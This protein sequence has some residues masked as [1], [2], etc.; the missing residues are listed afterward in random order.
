MCH[1]SIGWV[2]LGPHLDWQLGAGTGA[3]FSR[4]DLCPLGVPVAQWETLGDVGW[5]EYPGEL[6]VLL[7]TLLRF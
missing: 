1:Y 2:C 6:Q 7:E 5:E 4:S 3:L